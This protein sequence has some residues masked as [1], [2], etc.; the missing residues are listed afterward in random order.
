M[1]PFKHERQ[2]SS[3]LRGATIWYTTQSYF[4]VSG[5]SSGIP[6]VAGNIYI[7]KNLS[8]STQQ[9]WMFDREARW[10]AVLGDAKVN[11]PTVVDRI[12][13][14]RSDGSPNWVTAA[15]FANALSRRVRVSDV[16]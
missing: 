8:T 2:F 15:G 14:I 1:I 4:D 9:I 6:E 12:L 7:H 16:K 5:P 13:S 10:T 3:G 11:H